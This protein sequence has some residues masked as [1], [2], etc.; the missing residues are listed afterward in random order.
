MKCKKCGIETSADLC[1][2]HFYEE[3]EKLT[4]IKP[5]WIYDE[6][7]KEWVEIYRGIGL[8]EPEKDE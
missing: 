1:P 5:E 6:E 4:G 8:K 3:F 2:E 7:K